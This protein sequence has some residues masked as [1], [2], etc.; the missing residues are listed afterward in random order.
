MTANFMNFDSS[1]WVYRK[2]I[3]DMSIE[4]QYLYA[5]YWAS[6][7]LTTVGYGDFGAENNSELVISILWMGIGGAF[8][9]IVVGSLTSVMI[10]SNQ[11]EDQITNKK[12]A[13]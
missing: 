11:I 4:N 8:Y 1:T 2:E 13:L 9:A 5:F 7:T 3:I 10:E 6:Q 12:K